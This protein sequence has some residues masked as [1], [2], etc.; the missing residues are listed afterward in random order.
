MWIKLNQNNVHQAT[1]FEERLIYGELVDLLVHEFRGN[2]YEIALV[3]RFKDLQCN[4]YGLWHGKPSRKELL[5]THELMMIPLEQ[6]DGLIG[7][8]K[9]TALPR[10]FIMDSQLIITVPGYTPVRDLLGIFGLTSKS[11]QLSAHIVRSF[12]MTFYAQKS[13]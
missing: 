4:R 10:T 13:Q 6:L 2:S 8:V 11:T 12:Q 3:R 9:N 5:E 7:A 1:N